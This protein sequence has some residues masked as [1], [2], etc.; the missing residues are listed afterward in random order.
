MNSST[1]YPYTYIIYNHYDISELLSNVF[2]SKLLV[3]LNVRINKVNTTN[4]NG[5]EIGANKI[6]MTERLCTT[7]D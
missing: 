3:T 6:F 2:G 4:C 7:S 1:K 5:Y